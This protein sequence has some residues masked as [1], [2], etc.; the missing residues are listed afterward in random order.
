MKHKCLKYRSWKK[1]HEKKKHFTHIKKD[2]PSSKLATSI[3]G[4]LKDLV[5][6]VQTEKQVVQHLL[7]RK[8]LQLWL[9]G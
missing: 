6:I 5:S 1:N 8:Y 9:K 3:N 4:H 7:L 2:K